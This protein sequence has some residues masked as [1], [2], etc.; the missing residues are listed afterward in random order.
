MWSSG[1]S[2]QTSLVPELL[3]KNHN[4]NNR[5]ELEI[6]PWR[7]SADAQKTSPGSLN[8]LDPT[9]LLLKLIE[10]NSHWR[11]KVLDLAQKALS[12]SRL[13]EGTPLSNSSHLPMGKHLMIQTYL[14]GMCRQALYFQ[15]GSISDWRKS[16]PLTCGL[17]YWGSDLFWAGDL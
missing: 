10:K 5:K 6:P 14:L 15:L 8:S 11:E 9:K 13:Q 7:V 2:N 1:N 3:K 16:L 12:G 17:C 4:E